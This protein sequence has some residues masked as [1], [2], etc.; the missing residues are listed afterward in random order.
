MQE[1][2][3]PYPWLYEL[4]TPQVNVEQTNSIYS[5]HLGSI[6]HVQFF[7]PHFVAEGLFRGLPKYWGD[8]DPEYT[9]WHIR[10]SYFGKLQE[11]PHFDAESVYV[12]LKRGRVELVF[13]HN[14]L[15]GVM[16]LSSVTALSPIWAHIIAL[17][18]KEKGWDI[19]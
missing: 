11:M 2:F 17:V 6:A 13:F 10:H 15:A 1:P 5:Q 12:L 3:K 16:A 9:L 14:N 18:A 8:I 4:I 19:H 7:P